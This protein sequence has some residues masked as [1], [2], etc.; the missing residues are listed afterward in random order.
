MLNSS[1]LLDHCVEKAGPSKPKILFLVKGEKCL[2]SIGQVIG[3]E[4]YECIRVNVA[5][6]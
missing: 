4:K 6:R 1:P 2:M 3:N 5:M